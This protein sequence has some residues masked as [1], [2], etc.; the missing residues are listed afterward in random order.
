MSVV[1]IGLNHRTV[2]LDLLER[3]TVNEANLPKALADLV[4]RDHVSEAVVLSTCN[5]TEVYA[6][7]ERTGRLIVASEDRSFAGFVRAI[8]GHVVQR[9]PGTPTQALGQKNVPGIAQSLILEEAVVLTADDGTADWSDYVLPLLVARQL[10]MTW[11]VAS[12]FIEEQKAFPNEGAPISWR[13]LADAVATGLV[14]V[15][16]HSHTHAVMSSLTAAEA[17]AELDRSMALIEDRLGRA[18]AHFAYPKA[19]AP[20]H[21][22]DREVRTRFRTAALAGNRI[23]VS[24]RTDLA[25]LGRTPVQRCDDLTTFAHRV[26]GAGRTEGWVREQVDRRRHR[27]AVT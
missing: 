22:A 4:G 6:S 9:M 23:N 26:H 18:C 15:A 14:T 11:Y 21:D 8:Q 3:M 16:S 7:V 10:P 17:A 13:G 5:R 19:M 2:P 12:Q 27:H 24:G 25:R 20:S 1:V